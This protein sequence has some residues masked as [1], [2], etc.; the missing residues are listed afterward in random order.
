MSKVIRNN[1]Q[2][3]TGRGFFS[4]ISGR[5]FAFVPTLE[6]V[7][8]AIAGNAPVSSED[9]LLQRAANDDAQR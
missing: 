1:E 8:G 4:F 7:F 2:T 5:H 3:G 9:L 6:H